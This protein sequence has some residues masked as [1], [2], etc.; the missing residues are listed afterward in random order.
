MPPFFGTAQ[1]HSSL[2]Q[3]LE[4]IKLIKKLPKQGIPKKTIPINNKSHFQPLPFLNTVHTL[5]T[6]YLH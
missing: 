3:T 4:Q 5:A 2:V 1:E 6:T